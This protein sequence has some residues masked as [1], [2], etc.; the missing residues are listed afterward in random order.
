MPRRRGG[1]EVVAA[2]AAVITVKVAAV[3]LVVAGID[4]L[5]FTEVI[6][7]VYLDVLVV[8]EAVDVVVVDGLALTLRRSHCLMHWA[9]R[10]SHVIV[11][12]DV[13]LDVVVALRS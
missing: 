12:A 1:F 7:D 8:V 3:S 6:G 4:V 10:G 5:G 11:I 9:V 2:V 13:C